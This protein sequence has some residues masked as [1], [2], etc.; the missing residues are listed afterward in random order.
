MSRVPAIAKKGA[1]FNHWSRNNRARPAAARLANVDL[2]SDRIPPR[3]RLQC[4]PVASSI[5]GESTRPRGQVARQAP[6]ATTSTHRGRVYTQRPGTDAQAMRRA[7]VIDRME[8]YGYERGR[9]E[10]S[11]ARG[12]CC[13]HTRRGMAGGPVFFVRNMT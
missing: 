4:L 2:T 13:L 1:L 3:P 11:L 5:G 8:V 9:R 12:P 10:A 6:H 7:Q